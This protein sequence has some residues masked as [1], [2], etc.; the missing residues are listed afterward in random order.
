MPQLKL[1]RAYLAPWGAAVG[2][3]IGV[4]GNALTSKS[5]GGAGA[6]TTDK[7]PWAP[8]AGDIL[9]NVNT[10]QNLENAYLTSPQSSQQQAATQSIY[11]QDAYMQS[12]IP[13][14]LGQLQSQ[15]LGYTPGS[16]AAQTPFNFNASGGATIPG[17]LS[18]QVSPAG[19]G[20]TGTSGSPTVAAPAAAPASTFVNQGNYDPASIATLQGG[21]VPTGSNGSF[22]YGQAMPAPGSQ[23]YKDMSD[24]FAYGGNDPLNLYGHGNPLINGGGGDGTTSSNAP[25]SGTGGAF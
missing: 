1:S 21:K 24:Y 25:A 6:S 4:A 11:G 16:N 8:V 12:L 10:G 23:A 20:V 15:P 17:L 7:S 22:T 18:S 13:S 14:L 5:N 2:A 19:G 9:G 3:A